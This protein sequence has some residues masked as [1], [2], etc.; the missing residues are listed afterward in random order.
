MAMCGRRSACHPALLI[1]GLAVRCQ[2]SGQ[3]LNGTAQE[4]D[5]FLRGPASRLGEMRVRPEHY[6]PASV[7]ILG[8][9]VLRRVPGIFGR[10]E[11]A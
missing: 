4:G 7:R 9:G 6:H 3:Q 2:W 5:V 11:Q 8:L 1:G 10:R